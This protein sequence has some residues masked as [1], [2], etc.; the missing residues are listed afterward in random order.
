MNKMYDNDEMKKLFTEEQ[1]LMLH[2]TFHHIPGIGEKKESFLWSSGILSW[3]KFCEPY[4]VRLSPKTTELIESYLN[5]SRLEVKKENSRFFS[6]LLPSHLHWRFFPEF[7]HSAVYLDIET[8]GMDIY[9]GTITTIALY[10]G[11]SVS[12][13]VK[14]QNFKQFKEDIKKYNLI[15]T[16]NGKCFDIPFIENYFGIKLNQA[17]IDLRFIL[18]S[19]GY[20]GGLKSCEIAFGIDRG[21]LQGIDG[22]FAVLLWNDYI[23]N[24]NYKALETLLAYNSMDVVNLENL[25]IK[26]YNL[27]LVRT[28]FH[29]SHQLLLPPLPEIPFKPDR[30][31]IDKI[32]QK[33]VDE[34]LPV[35]DLR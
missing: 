31:T 12:V 13:Y 11:T 7:R 28:P 3:D 32:K 2:N 4:P 8:N 18:G 33:Y 15:I 24:G 23:I 5:Y 34:F 14:N 29:K 1:L 22:Y 30:E 6:D 19:L 16:Y 26:A 10:D 27:K 21:D 9:Q 20:K 25:M 17:H 35:Y